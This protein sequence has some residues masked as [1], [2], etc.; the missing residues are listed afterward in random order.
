MIFASH[1]SAHELLLDLVTQTSFFRSCDEESPNR[2]KNDLL[3]WLMTTLEPPEHFP[4]P[5]A[6][7]ARLYGHASQIRFWDTKI[8]PLWR[9]HTASENELIR[10]QNDFFGGNDR[11]SHQ[12]DSMNF[13]IRTKKYRV[14]SPDFELQLVFWKL[15]VLR[16]KKSHILDLVTHF[17]QISPVGVSPLQNFHHTV[18]IWS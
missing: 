8:P 6:S 13:Q 18:T 4:G 11:L 1:L 10:Y 5:K 2:T 16:H 14:V 15:A 7:F 9:S 12:G 3:L 17:G